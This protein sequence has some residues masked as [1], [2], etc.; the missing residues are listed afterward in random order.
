MFAAAAST[1]AGSSQRRPQEPEEA[2]PA[3][4]AR[5]AASLFGGGDSGAA[6]RS[7]RA[8]AK[9]VCWVKSKLANLRCV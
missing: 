3:G 9:Q 8:P 7:R 6:G 1:A 5:L 2:V 4:K